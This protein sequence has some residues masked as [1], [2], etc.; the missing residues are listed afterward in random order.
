[1]AAYIIEYKYFFFF[2]FFY[3]LLLFSIF[4][5]QYY[6]MRNCATPQPCNQIL[7]YRYIMRYNAP[8]KQLISLSVDDHSTLNIVFS[9]FIKAENNYIVLL[10]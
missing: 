10:L 4:W 9:N 8:Q 7:K 5:M 1:M 6:K 2:F 3:R